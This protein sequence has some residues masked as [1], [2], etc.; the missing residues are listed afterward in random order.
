MDKP[1]AKLINPTNA[2][3]GHTKPDDFIKSF[4]WENI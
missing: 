4:S 2:S 3:S 1:L